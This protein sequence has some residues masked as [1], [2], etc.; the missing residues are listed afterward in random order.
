M[1]VTPGVGDS[2]QPALRRT[3]T[4]SRTS[5]IGASIVDTLMQFDEQYTNANAT[6]HHNFRNDMFVIESYMTF[7]LQLEGGE[8]FHEFSLWRIDV[9]IVSRRRHLHAHTYMHNSGINFTTTEYGYS[10]SAGYLAYGFR[11]VCHARA[12]LCLRVAK[13]GDI[14]PHPLHQLSTHVRPCRA[15]SS[16]FLL[17]VR[18]ICSTSRAAGDEGYPPSDLLHHTEWFWAHCEGYSCAG[19]IAPVPGSIPSELTEHISPCHFYDLRSIP[20]TPT[21]TTTW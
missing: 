19:T 9:A 7:S 2:H 20:P 4:L 21:P 3:P 16:S 11:K 13:A 17:L 12:I 15:F 18:S 8:L 14:Y 5:G 10:F 6:F 1:N